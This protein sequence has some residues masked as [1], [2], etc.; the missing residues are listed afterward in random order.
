MATLTSPRSFYGLLINR[1]LT[2]FAWFLTHLVL[3]QNLAPF[4]VS[5]GVLQILI[6]LACKQ[7]VHHHEAQHV[8]NGLLCYRKLPCR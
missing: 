3:E 8:L 2:H 7:E 1:S 6:I 5:W 4:T